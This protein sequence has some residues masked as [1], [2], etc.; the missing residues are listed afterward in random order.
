[1]RK[2][3]NLFR[4]FNGP[5]GELVQRIEELLEMAKK[6]EITSVMIAAGADDGT[7]M[8]GYCN[9]DIVERQLLVAHQ[10]IDITMAVLAANE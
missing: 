3:G 10:Q 9:V 7:I 1:M 8:T 4:L 5:R 2:L 6:G